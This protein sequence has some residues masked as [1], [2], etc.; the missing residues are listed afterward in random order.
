MCI[1]GDGSGQKYYVPIARVEHINDPSPRVTVTR[2]PSAHTASSSPH[3]WR[4][5]PGGLCYVM[6]GS[7]RCSADRCLGRARSLGGPSRRLS[8][9]GKCL[10]PA[11][12]WRQLPCRGI[13]QVRRSARPFAAHLDEPHEPLLAVN[14]DFASHPAVFEPLVACSH[15]SL[16]FRC[17]HRPCTSLANPAR[18]DRPRAERRPAAGP[19]RTGRGVHFWKFTRATWLGESQIRALFGRTPPPP[20]TG[21]LR[22]WHMLPADDIDVGPVARVVDC[23]PP[24]SA[25]IRER[26][27]KCP[28]RGSLPKPV[29]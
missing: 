12:P 28:D 15:E 25:G 21:A 1:D 10:A 26:A 18:S 2:P 29:R 5:H 20:T 19:M 16:G 27:T 24:C 3:A 22:A 8:V 14:H 6:F 9:G 4:R 17:R 13:L 23:L 11:S 7:A